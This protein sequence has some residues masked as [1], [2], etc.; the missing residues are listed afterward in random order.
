MLNDY[1][2]I[3]Y[4]SI[5]NQLCYVSVYQIPPGHVWLEGDNPFNS[6]DSRSY[7]PL[8]SALV[9]GRVFAKV[10]PPSQARWITRSQGR[11]QA[12]TLVLQSFMRDAWIR[13]RARVDFEARASEVAAQ[14]AAALELEQYWR[15]VFELMQAGAHHVQAPLSAAVILEGDAPHTANQESALDS[16]LSATLGHDIEHH[17]FNTEGS[18]GFRSVAD[19]SDP[20][21]IGHKLAISIQ[22]ERL[23]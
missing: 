6:S 1:V 4:R 8:P 17:A 2:N 9:L 7:G 21:I 13:E 12:N 23:S 22:D 5:Q 11:P 18:T 15:A 20:P 19:E 16:P 10:W 3:Y 14:Q